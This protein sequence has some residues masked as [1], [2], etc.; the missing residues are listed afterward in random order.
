M[1]APHRPRL[2][3]PTRRPSLELPT[4]NRQDYL[5]TLLVGIGLMV[6]VLYIFFRV[7]PSALQN[8][9]LPNSY[10]LLLLLWFGATFFISMYLTLSTRRGLLIGVW[11]TF[12]IFF[13][14]QKLLNPFVFILTTTIIFSLEFALTIMSRE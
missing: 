9:L 11:L 12:L 1:T 8:F 3:Q 13:Q 14:I 4:K 2:N 6:A 5:G 10:F 7:P